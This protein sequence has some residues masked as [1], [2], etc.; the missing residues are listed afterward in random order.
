MVVK[1]A[2]GQCWRRVGARLEPKPVQPS[3]RTADPNSMDGAD[4]WAKTL[5]Q[6]MAQTKPKDIWELVPQENLASGHLDSSGF[7]YQLRGLSRCG[8]GAS[9]GVPGGGVG[10]GEF[11]SPPAS[12]GCGLGLEGGR[13]SVCLPGL[14]T[15]QVGGRAGSSPSLLG[16]GGVGGA[17]C[18][19][20]A[21]QAS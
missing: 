11:A 19:L 14:G 10:G 5:V 21:A 20:P 2:I 4:V 15:Q 9:C 6:L 16:S 8:W 7:Q 18:P 17:V 3:D 1:A 13:S 12:A